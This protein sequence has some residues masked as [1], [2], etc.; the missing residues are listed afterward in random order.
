[1]E[2]LKMSLKTPMEQYVDIE[3]LFTR[4]EEE[5]KIYHVQNLFQS[6][7]DSSIETISKG[8]STSYHS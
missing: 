4:L 2:K 7:F 6:I 5:N 1:M 3:E 8:F